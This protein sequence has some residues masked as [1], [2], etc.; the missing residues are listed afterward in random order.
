MKTDRSTLAALVGA[1]A[2]ARPWSLPNQP[3]KHS[4][5]G[6]KAYRAKRKRINKIQRRAR[7]INRLK[8]A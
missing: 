7:R 5:P 1:A 2:G 8:A 3:Q 6:L 4:G